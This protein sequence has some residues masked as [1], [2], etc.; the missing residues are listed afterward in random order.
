[1]KKVRIS[2]DIGGVLSK[3]PD[4]WRPIFNAL[5]D[6]NFIEVYVITDMHKP[7]QSMKML[8]DNGFILKNPNNLI[9]SNFS[10]YGEVCKTINQLEHEIDVHI[11]DFPGYLAGGADIRL[12]VMPDVTKPYYHDTWKTDGIEGDF[13]RRKKDFCYNCYSITNSEGVCL[14]NCKHI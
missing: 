8:I 10:K 4:I 7:E 13:G 1:M 3:Y 12:M 11:D 6:S 14:N 5:Q 2:F 9:N